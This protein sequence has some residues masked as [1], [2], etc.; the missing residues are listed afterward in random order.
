LT[1]FNCF[2]KCSDDNE[3]IVP[4]QCPRGKGGAAICY[5]TAIGKA[6]EE[7]Q[8]GGNRVATI[9]NLLNQNHY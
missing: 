3:P 4:Y 6:V 9:T 1:D 7:K 8:D 2:V 5:K